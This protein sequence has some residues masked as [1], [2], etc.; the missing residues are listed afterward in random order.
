MHENS[1]VR[2]TTA[3]THRG[4]RQ[5]LG[6]T[7]YSAAAL[8]NHSVAELP[9]AFVINV[10]WQRAPFSRG[11]LL[12]GVAVGIMTLIAPLEEIG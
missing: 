12:S 4:L 7:F 10:G 2:A 1:A 8:A 5:M 3:R 9:G 11:K 6:D